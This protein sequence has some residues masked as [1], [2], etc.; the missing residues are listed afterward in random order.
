MKQKVS[1]HNRCRAEGCNQFI[2]MNGLCKVHWVKD[3][4]DA[5]V[6]AKLERSESNE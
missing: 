4:L 1:G 2:T 5:R 3:A 6:E